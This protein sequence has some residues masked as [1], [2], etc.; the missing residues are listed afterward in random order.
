MTIKD[1]SLYPDRDFCFFFNPQTRYFFVQNI[2]I[3][4]IKL[5]LITYKVYVIIIIII[6][7]LFLHTPVM[8]AT[9]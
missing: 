3:E 4:N 1:T 9:G 7:I 6:I 5:S 2:V 8:L